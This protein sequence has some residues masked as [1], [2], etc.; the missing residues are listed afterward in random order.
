MP[1]CQLQT[2][3]ARRSTALR[4]TGMAGS[5]TLPRGSTRS[6]LS[7][8]ATTPSARSARAGALTSRLRLL[9][10]RRSN[11]SSTPALLSGRESGPCDERAH[12][13]PA[14]CVPVVYV[15]PCALSYGV[16]LARAASACVYMG[17]S[18]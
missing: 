18:A 15:L 7:W 9:G 2:T 14:M 10:T 8:T 13:V 11:S 4:P 1:R 12:V 3:P 5:S 6:G 17:S 16:R